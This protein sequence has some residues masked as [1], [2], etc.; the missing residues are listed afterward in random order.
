MIHYYDCAPREDGPEDFLP[1]AP[2][3]PNDIE[4][5]DEWFDPE[6]PLDCDDRPF[7]FDEG[8]VA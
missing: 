4:N 8:G 1:I 5:L 7:I 2:L 3:W 6:R